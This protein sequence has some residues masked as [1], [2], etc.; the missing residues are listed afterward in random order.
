MDIMTPKQKKQLEF[1]KESVA[2]WYR[3]WK[4][5]NE[6]YCKMRNFVFKSTVTKDQEAALDLLK[7]PKLGFNILEMFLSRQRGEFAKHEPDVFGRADDNA[8]VPPQL[9]DLVEG[10]L[11][12]MLHEANEDGFEYQIYSECSSGGFSTA[13]TYLDYRDEFSFEQVVK[14]EKSFD[15]LLVGFDPLA[16]KPHKADGEYCFEVFPLT[17]KEFKNRFS[18][19]DIKG[20]KFSANPSFDDFTF[21]YYSG[22]KKM[23]LLCYFY[24]K[25][26]TKMTIHNI[27]DPLTGKMDNRGM[28]DKE[29]K[30]LIKTWKNR[31]PNVDEPKIISSRTTFKTEVYRYIFIDNQILSP[32]DVDDDMIE[33]DYGVN[34]TF[35]DL[36]IVFFDG[37][38][39]ILRESPQAASKQ[40]VRAFHHNAVGVQMLKNVAGQTIANEMENLSQVRLAMPSESMDNTQLDLYKNP[41]STQILPY[42]QYMDKNVDKPLNPPTIIP[43][44]E[45][46]ASVVNIFQL[47]DQATQMCMGSFD[48]TLG[49]L[50]QDVS[51]A[52]FIEAATQSNAAAMPYIVNFIKSL[53]RLAQVA[54]NM[55]P[56]ILTN[57]SSVPI[58]DRK[59]EKQTVDLNSPEF[60]P[61]KNATDDNTIK[62]AADFIKI[63]VE[64]GVNFAIQKTRA[65]QQIM[66]LLPL[67]PRLSQILN[68]AEG[69]TYFLNNMDFK[70]VDKLIELNKEMAKQEAKQPPAPP[71]PA[72]ME[73]QRKTKKDQMDAQLQAASIK[74]DQQQVQNKTAEIALEHQRAQMEAAAQIA[75]AQAEETRANSEVLSGVL[76]DIHSHSAELRDQVHGQNLD[77]AK[78]LLEERKADAVEDKNQL[79]REKFEHEKT[80][81][82]QAVKSNKPNRKKI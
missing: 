44:P 1:M 7:R 57:R 3:Y 28:P 80:V 62:Y 68:T 13:K 29:Y 26:K 22:N 45:I 56:Q 35:P 11:R 15:S 60:E 81:S 82:K 12:Y 61:I 27:T 70:N 38:S 30:E 58:I 50:E 59:G 54:A 76:S 74:N 46:P 40:V 39:E 32:Y 23:I 8:N 78:H 73:I 17:E 41:Q 24:H 72:V 65:L 71:P 63:K 37:N 49:K 20:L 6:Y 33:K 53:G 67:M 43:R 14:M 79:E 31:Y 5:N 2:E 48:S 55:L 51:R 77:V 18:K 34:T 25:R 9:L 75:K 42:Q 47:C 36:P 64:A 4:D 10:A 21:S 19:I 16:R 66:A 69:F 52:A